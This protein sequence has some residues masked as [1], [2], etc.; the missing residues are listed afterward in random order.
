MIINNDALTALKTLPDASV[1]MCVT[2]PP[3][4][5]LRDY[6]VA[7]Q[8]GL[9][10]TPEEYIGRLVE[11]F[12]EVR[13]VLKDNGTLWVVIGD[14]YCGSGKNSGGRYDDSLQA[15]SAPHSWATGR[16]KITDLK[17]KDLIGV[18]WMLA[19]ALRADGWWLRQDLIW[20]KP[21]PMPQSVTDRFTTNH[22]YVFLLSKSKNYYFND[23]AAL[24]PAQYDGRKDTRAKGCHK[25]YQ[26]GIHA[27]ATPQSMAGWGGIGHERWRRDEF[28]GFLRLRRG[29]FTV[30]T[31][32]YHGA[33]FATFPTELIRPFILVG[34][35]RGD[36][37]LDP[38]F[39][40]GT[41]GI[42]AVENGRDCIGI[43]LNPEY[44]KL[45]R[46]RLSSVAEQMNIFADGEN[47]HV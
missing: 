19:F 8:I 46:Q 34:S 7:G 26:D 9:E 32:A 14:S 31:K 35:K 18:P 4:Y 5:A 17:P 15:T 44:C 11:V 6:G 36:V 30:A 42:V 47:N 33:H 38:F 39:G 43:E 37:V 28:G 25:Y 29:V 23:V 3:Y 24:E 13:R 21:N 45:A 2:S 27:N 12:R 40:A 20:V 1:Q 41:T 10:D 22:E 16:T